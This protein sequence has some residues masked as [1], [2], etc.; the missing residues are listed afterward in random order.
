MTVLDPLLI[1]SPNQAGLTSLLL[2][3]LD[4]AAAA[5]VGKAVIRGGRLLL[6][7]DLSSH[8]SWSVVTF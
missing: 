3:R 4:L 7:S 5:C 6:R 8:L 1:Q 2:S